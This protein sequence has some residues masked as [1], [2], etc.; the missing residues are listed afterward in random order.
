MWLPL[1]LLSKPEQASRVWHTVTVL[2]RFGPGFA[3]RRRGRICRRWRR[4]W[5]RV[6]GDEWDHGVELHPLRDQLVGALRP[7]MLNV[8]GAVVLVL[9][10]ACANVANLLL[11]RARTNRRE[12]A[13]R[14]ALG[15]SGRRLFGESLALTLILCLVGGALGTV[16]AAVTL[17]LLRVALSHTAGVDRGL[18]QSIH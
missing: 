4:G 12:V 7:A 11:V 15:A 6:S 10:I 5:Q 16:F 2:G 8:M 13:V 17:P 3:W 9:L 1:S 14:Q 18:I